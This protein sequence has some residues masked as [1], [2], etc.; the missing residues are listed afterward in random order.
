[1]TPDCYI[2]LYLKTVF[3]KITR[4]RFKILLSVWGDDRFLAGLLFSQKKNKTN[5]DKSRPLKV[6]CN[7]RIKK[8]SKFAWFFFGNYCNILAKKLMGK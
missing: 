6:L 8:K 3:Y 2:K 1:M 5:F 7:L 4:A